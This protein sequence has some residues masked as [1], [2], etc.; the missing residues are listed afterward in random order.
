MIRIRVN[1]DG[2][3]NESS[4]RGFSKYLPYSINVFISTWISTNYLAF[5]KS[6]L[7]ESKEWMDLSPMPC[8]RLGSSQSCLDRVV[9]VCMHCHLLGLGCVPTRNWG[10]GKG[11]LRPHTTGLVCCPDLCSSHYDHVV[12]KQHKKHT[13]GQ[14]MQKSIPKCGV[15]VSVKF[16]ASPH[17]QGFQALEWEEGKGQ[18][19]SSPTECSESPVEI[20]RQCKVI[21]KA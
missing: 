10:S 15:P 4:W 12:F 1:R 21:S 5:R 6:H 7:I 14:G 20:Y 11:I 19:K 13:V 16:M 8:I 18:T 17:R 2:Y 9:M 3:G